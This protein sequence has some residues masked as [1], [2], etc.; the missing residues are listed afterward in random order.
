MISRIRGTLLRR[1]I[2]AAEVM[3]AGGVGYELHIPLGVYER[4]PRE[5][6]DVELRV[7]QVVREDAQELYGFMDHAERAM[8]GKLL[9]ASGVGPKLALNIMSSM[10]PERIVRAIVDRDIAALR[11]IPGL[12]AKKAEKL[13]LELADRLDDVAVATSGGGTPAFD[14]AVKA[15][16]A[17]GYSSADAA[18][19][20]RKVADEQGAMPPVDLIKA[21]L[22]AMKR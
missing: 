9:S 3:T 13:A 14:E 1:E 16:V 12:G 6:A 8:F 2:G 11:R 7:F 21:A 4:L 19:A 17:L 10:P 18:A 15:L 22:A 5:G 20:V